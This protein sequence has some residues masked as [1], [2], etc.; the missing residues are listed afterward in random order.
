MSATDLVGALS[1]CEFVSAYRSDGC[2]EPMWVYVGLQI[3]W[4]LWV[5]QKWL[6]TNGRVKR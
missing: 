4:V 5:S 6:E 2:S 3:W 1:L